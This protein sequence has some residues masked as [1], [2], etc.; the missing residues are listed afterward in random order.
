MAGHEELWRSLNLD[1]EL[2][3]QILNAIE[4]SFA[5]KVLRQPDRPKA[6]AYFDN[7]LHGAHGERVKEIIDQ[8]NKGAKFIGT[9]CIYVPEEIILALGASSLALCGGTALSI[10]YAEKMFPRNICPLVKSTLGLAFSKTCPYAPI[11]DLAVGETTCDAKKKAWDVL[12]KK[13]RFHVL[14]VPQK[15]GPKDRE[16]WQEEVLHFKK[17]M[18]E[19]TGRQLEKESLSEAIKILNRKRSALA[20]LNTFRK[21]ENPPISGLDTLV[22]LQAALLDDPVRFTTQL[23]HLNEELDQRV[24]N[25]E[26]KREKRTPRLMISGCPSV[27]GNWKIHYLLESSG[28]VIVADETCTGTR[29]FQNLVEERDGDIEEMLRSIAD[30]YLNIHCSCFSPNEERIQDII[31]LVK[32]FKVDGVVHYI[33]SYCHTYNIETI[34]IDSALKKEGILSLKIE[35]DYSEEDTG[36][37]RMRIEAFLEGIKQHVS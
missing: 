23:E 5:E 34:N 3:Q 22:V 9:F 17:Q 6:M 4:K 8:K 12:A 16:L 21:E 28:A 15:K 1:L 36:Q 33:L 27:M 25:Q 31:N 29:Y 14:E 26:V 32:E 37:L 11:K 24:K 19:V 20:R 30:R 18:E 35:T 13:V 2:H 7:V 10:P